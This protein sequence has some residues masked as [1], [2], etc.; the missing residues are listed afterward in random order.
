MT[1]CSADASNC[2]ETAVLTLFMFD[3]SNSVEHRHRLLLVDLE[4][5]LLPLKSLLDWRVTGSFQLVRGKTRSLEMEE[6]VTVASKLWLGV[7]GTANAPQVVH[8]R[9]IGQ[10]PTAAA[11]EQ[12]KCDTGEGL[13]Q[14]WEAQWQ[15]FLRTL[16]ASDSECGN[17]QKC[18]EPAP[19]DDAKAFLASF[20]QVVLA[21]RWPRDKWVSFLLPALRGEAEQAFSSLSDRDRED[22]GKVKAAILQR[23]AVVRERQRQRFRQLCYQEAEGPR[24]VYGQLQHLCRRWL[25]AE[26]HS[27]EE[28]LELLI[29]EQFLTVLPQEM[30]SWVRE[31]GP[32][33]CAQAVALAEEFPLKGQQEAEKREQEA[34]EMTTNEFEELQTPQYEAEVRWILMFVIFSELL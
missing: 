1:K 34:R 16:Q 11:P 29:L 3:P 32:E 6:Q 17:A 30:Q 27:K 20:E 24:A 25:N 8:V 13:Q 23:E 10:L 15:E 22:Y 33:S 26:R 31:C 18:E 28:I 2:H 4:N 9:S 14:R 5:F 7:G 21:C 12:V 19:W